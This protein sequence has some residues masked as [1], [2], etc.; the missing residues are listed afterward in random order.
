MI[1]CGI[2]VS[3]SSLD[4]FLSG[5]SKCFPNDERGFRL[6][7]GFAKG[8]DLFVMEASGSYHL[9]LAEWLH[10][11]G[12]AVSVVNPAQSFFASGCAI[13]PAPPAADRNPEAKSAIPC[14]RPITRPPTFLHSTIRIPRAI[15]HIP[16]SPGSN[17]R[18]RWS[19]KTSRETRPACHGRSAAR[20]GCR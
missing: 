3:K 8:C 19:A 11:H 4:V 17:G 5:K 18:R 10:A 13:L 7:L 14:P 9:A 12:R 1:V 15:P 6:L 20:T 16:P 2:D